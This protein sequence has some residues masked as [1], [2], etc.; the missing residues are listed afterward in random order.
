MHRSSTRPPLALI[1]APRVGIRLLCDLVG[2]VQQGID[3]EP[4][5]LAILRLAE[6]LLDQLVQFAG[7]SA[8]HGWAIALSRFADGGYGGGRCRGLMWRKGQIEFNRHASARSTLSA[9][10]SERRGDIGI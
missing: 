8:L 5:I 7:E 6:V 2:G 4:K 1:R 9:T 10:L 3:D